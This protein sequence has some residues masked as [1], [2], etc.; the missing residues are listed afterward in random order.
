[1]SD[2]KRIRELI[3]KLNI[4][5]NSYYNDNKSLIT[6]YHYDK[7]FD[8]LKKLEE[9]TGIC[10]PDSPTQSV[11]YK[12]VNI[13]EEVVHNHP[14]LSLDKTQDPEEAIKYFGNHAV[15]MMPKMDGLTCTLRYV[16][17]ML[18]SAETRG[19]GHVGELITHNAPH[20][21]GIPL[22]INI[23]DEVIVDGE[24]IMT[25]ETFKEINHA[26]MIAGEE[27]FKHP[28]NL[29]S[30]SVRQ[31]NS[32]ICASRNCRFVAWKLVKGSESSS[33]AE[34]LQ[35]LDDLNFM[36]VRYYFLPKLIR[37]DF[38]M[39]CTRIREEMQHLDYPI[40]GLVIGFNDIEYGKSLG[41]TAHH[42]KDQIAFKFYDDR[43]P[44]H[45]RNI[46]WTMGKTGILTP[47]AV[48]DTVLI[49]GTEVSR[50]SL[51]NITI[52]EHLGIKK[53]CTG[54]VYKANQI[55]PQIDYCEDDGSEMFDIPNKCPI[56]NGAVERIKENDSEM[57]LCTNINCDGKRL[58]KLSSFVSKT[59]LD[60][61]G[62]SKATIQ[63][64]MDMGFISDYPSIYTLFNHKE[65]L[66][67]IDGMGLTSVGSI[68]DNIEKSRNVKLEKFISAINIPNISTASA[69][70]ISHY[71][72]NDW[73]RFKN[74][75][76]TKF[77]LS[78]IEGIGVK[79]CSAI[80]NWWSENSTEINRL[81]EFMIWDMPEQTDAKNNTAFSGKKFC[82]TGS[83]EYSREEIKRELESYGGIFVSGVSKKL[84]YLF[85]GDNAGSKLQKAKD[86]GIQ[87]VEEE[88]Y[89]SFL[90]SLR[91]E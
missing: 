29:A 48:F 46:D 11:G 34:R 84:D 73:V 39:Y 14:M 82:I 32:K 10:Y 15:V 28:R 7:M 83:F 20:I 63:K 55:I 57:L 41:S 74:A 9:E 5:R 44:T 71:F 16:D 13:L 8:E 65:D 12:V 31:L 25:W 53:D 90:S 85:V 50:A 49:D 77:D 2:N 38:D 69:K 59:G 36:V 45:V 30:G 17:G 1:M 6:D 64:F 56:C 67:K 19:D 60:I 75:L 27:D 43:H 88:Y 89:S 70:T 24:V 66:I 54:Y 58:G 68:L 33:F 18:V 21:M 61:E 35:I 62:M 3:D 40:D 80:L 47:T 42:F 79:T 22:T 4:Y 86:L 51:H 91:K 52:M 26:R 81:A 23:K 87:I 37:E 76:D 72:G 78:A